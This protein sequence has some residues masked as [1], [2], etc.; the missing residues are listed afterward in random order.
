MIALALLY[1]AGQVARRALVDAC[2]FVLFLFALLLAAIW[3]WA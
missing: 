2:L 3:R 1:S